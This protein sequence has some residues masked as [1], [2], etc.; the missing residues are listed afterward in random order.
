MKNILPSL[1]RR[2]SMAKKYRQAAENSLKLSDDSTPMLFDRHGRSNEYIHRISILEMLDR[3]KML[4]P[5]PIIDFRN[6][7]NI[8]WVE[9]YQKN[10][11]TLKAIQ[12]LDLDLDIYKE[13]IDSV[14]PF[15]VNLKVVYP[16]AASIKLLPPEPTSN[17]FSSTNQ[18]TI[19]SVSSSSSSSSSKK[20]GKKQKQQQ[21]QQQE[22]TAVLSN[23]E[24]KLSPS[25]GS[26]NQK[27]QEQTQTQSNYYDSALLGNYLEVGQT[28]EKPKVSYHED[29]LGKN[30]LYT[31][32]LFTPDFPCRLKPDSNVM[33][34]WMVN[35]IP[36]N[37][38]SE[39]RTTV[40]YLMPLPPE[41]AGTFRYVFALFKQNTGKLAFQSSTMTTT[42]ATAATA[43]T[44]TSSSITNI[45]QQQVEGNNDQ[46]SQYEMIMNNRKFS[47][48]TEEFQ[49]LRRNFNLFEFIEKNSLS[50]YPQGIVFF[51]TEYEMA[52]TTKYRELNIDEPYYIPPDIEFMQANKKLPWTKRLNSH[53]WQ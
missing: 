11:E 23:S 41:Y 53:I 5:V 39:G 15:K 47:S 30:D 28:A 45:V 52:V 1:R 35:D 36:R 32:M 33:L 13:R 17:F 51:R 7:K 3:R 22:A 20:A 16:P 46:Q 27:E 38:I 34:H 18:E 29:G 44:T 40:D 2:Y 25:S 42:A 31:L 9:T 19:T 50:K 4:P 6:M 37:K 43:T 48:A 12:L 8:P 49:K 24:I 21:Q 14:L 26:I 10:M